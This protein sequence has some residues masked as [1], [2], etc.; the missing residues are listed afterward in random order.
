MK[1]ANTLG[2][3]KLQPAGSEWYEAHI[4]RRVRCYDLAKVSDR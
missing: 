3:T 1:S 2:R 4:S